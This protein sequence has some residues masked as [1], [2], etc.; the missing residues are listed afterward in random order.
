MLSGRNH[1]ALLDRSRSA[2]FV[3][4]VQE[5]FRDYVEGFDELAANL[6]LLAAGAA[7][8][9]VPIAASEQYRTGLGATVPEL[10][11]DP[12]TPTYDKVTFAACDTPAW[13]ELPSEVRN[14]DQLVLAGIE[15]H[16]CVRQTALALLAAGR[17]VHVVVDAVG[18]HSSVH[19]DTAIAGLERAGALLTTVEQALFDWLGT[20]GTPEFRDVQALVKAHVGR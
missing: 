17:E 1:E 3:I 19:R 18:S 6:R 11:L 16:V 14:A 5:A 12:A 13:D 8:L 4:D 15:A 2:L 10:G 9:D 7:R 20:A